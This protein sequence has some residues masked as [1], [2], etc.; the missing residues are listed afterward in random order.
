M[1]LTLECPHCREH[2][3]EHH[4]I[5]DVIVQP[6]VKHYT[7]M[8]VSIKLDP[9]PLCVDEWSALDKLVLKEM[10]IF[11]IQPHIQ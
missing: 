3:I 8:A 4:V 10:I 2:E 9:L 5:A 11:K 6:A 7:D 1:I